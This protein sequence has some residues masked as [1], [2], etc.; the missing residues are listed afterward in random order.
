MWIGVNVWARTHRGCREKKQHDE[1]TDNI[2]WRGAWC[3]RFDAILKTR[4]VPIDPR[5]EQR[6]KLK[7]RSPRRKIQEQAVGIGDCKFADLAA[8]DVFLCDMSEYAAGQ[9]FWRGAGIGAAEFVEVFSLPLR[10]SRLRNRS[11]RCLPACSYTSDCSCVGSPDR[12]CRRS[13][14]TRLHRRNFFLP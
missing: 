7:L 13:R 2:V 1:A 6:C 8:V 14:R 11:G 10:C 9:F 3:R 12:P 5:C 4:S